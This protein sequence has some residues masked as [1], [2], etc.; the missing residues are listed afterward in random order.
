MNEDCFDDDRAATA[1]P[2]RSVIS[3]PIGHTMK[4]PGTTSR[5]T[6]KKAAFLVL[7][8][9]LQTPTASA[10]L[11]TNH[12]NGPFHVRSSRSTTQ[13]SMVV[14]GVFDDSIME[15]NGCKNNDIS[16]QEFFRAG[17][18][19][20]GVST[21]LLLLHPSTTNAMMTDPKTGIALPEEG[22]IEHAI[23]TDWTDVDN[24]V[25]ATSG[26][27]S[28][29]S[30][31]GRLDSSPDSLFYTDPRL[32]EHVDEQA[33]NA[34]TK[35]I[36][37]D[38]IGS[39]ADGD[40][41]VLDLCSSWTS[42]I[43]LSSTTTTGSNKKVS[44][45]GLGMNAKELAQNPVLN[46]WVVKDLNEKPILPYDDNTFDVVLCQL[47]IDYLTRPLEVLKEA[48]RVLK[49]NGTVHILFSNRLFLSKV[50]FLIVCLCV[51]LWLRLYWCV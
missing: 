38:A 33:V 4:I 22:E 23:P 45:S 27:S 39:V 31:L 30:G 25:E 37:N 6:R 26:S 40:I 3:K 21:L 41:R 2:F 51:C 49:P 15:N 48:G 24:P 36:S 12:G 19:A 18:A 10:W 43:D 14:P 16:R 7:V 20:V 9:L 11:S 47:S 28:S 1:Q 8:C 35:Y 17:T 29:S 46:D 5:G 34:M 42:H 13:C 50:R 44:V 32:V